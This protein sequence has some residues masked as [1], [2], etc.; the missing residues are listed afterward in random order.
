MGWRSMLEDNVPEVNAC[1]S[2]VG[3]IVPVGVIDGGVQ[4][5]GAKQL[6]GAIELG[7]TIRERLGQRGTG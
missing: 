2:I 4:D 3:W 5:T 6:E 7:G 1:V